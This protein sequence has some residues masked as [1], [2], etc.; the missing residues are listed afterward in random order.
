MLESRPYQNLEQLLRV[1]DRNWDN[2]QENDYLQAFEGHA[3][4]GDV[5][6]LQAK[7]ASTEKLAAT[8]HAMVNQ[9]DHEVIEQL[10]RGNL[11]YEQKF[12]FIF[13]VCATGKSA[14]EML[15]VLRDRLHND[16]ETE[17]SNAIEEQRKIFQLRL[18]KLF[19]EKNG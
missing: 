18:K 6:S 8:E 4:I 16:R 10:A 11:D 19:S 1:A 3:K 2:L 9:A 14:I 15:A 13:M 12:G 5:N 7:Y 17:L